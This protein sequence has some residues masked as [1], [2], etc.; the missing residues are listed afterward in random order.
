VCVA[1]QQQCAIRRLSRLQLAILASCSEHAA[2]HSDTS[3]PLLDDG[4]P[5]LAEDA[6]VTEEWPSATPSPE[7]AAVGRFAA[8]DFPHEILLRNHPE[9]V[10]RRQA[11]GKTLHWLDLMRE[12]KVPSS[13]LAQALDQIEAL[14][15]TLPLISFAQQS[16]C[17]CCTAAS[18]Q[19]PFCHLPQPRA[20]GG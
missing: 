1:L 13:L 16:A 2:Q 9:V 12:S 6:Q 7:G 15:S 10:K 17:P 4:A 11:I 3:A 8:A 19:D 18:C 20:V 5:H 14:T